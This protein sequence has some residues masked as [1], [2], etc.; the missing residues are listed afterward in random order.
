MS[1]TRKIKKLLSQWEH[2]NVKNEVELVAEDSLM[3]ETTSKKP[4]MEEYLAN[5]YD[6][7]FNVLTGM[8]EYRKKNEGIFCALDERERNTLYME[9]RGDDIKCT[10]SGLLR[11]LHS[12]LIEEFHPFRAYFQMLPAWDGKDRLPDLAKRVSDHPL[13]IKAFHRWMLA[14]AAQW[15]GIGHLHANSV[16]PILISTE[17]GMMKSTFCKSLMPSILEGYYTDK[18]DL[19]A[20]GCLEHKL[21]LMGII[22]LD[23]FDCIPDQ[24]MAQLKN[25]M[26][27]SSVT[28]RQAYKKNF[29]QLPRIASFI[30]TSNRPDLLTDPTGSRRFVCVEVMRK[31]DCSNMEMDHIYAQ[32]KAEL[33]AG[34]RYWFTS[35]EEQEIQEHNASFYQVRP[36]EELIRSRYRAPLSGEQYEMLSLI[37]I[38]DGLRS[39]HSHLLRRCDMKRFGIILQTIG[40]EKVHTRYG[41]RYKVVCVKGEGCER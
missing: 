11:F 4:K 27:M 36:E 10:F 40:M 41:N 1:Q 12:S 24:R 34:E 14:L 35:A 2:E 20:Q 28:I 6:F 39:E 13:W 33:A 26:Q 7:R 30:G 16:A 22:N 19:T 37:E 17:Q 3:P 9:L 38:L 5:R 21:A 8:T 23:E 25:L 15:M 32:L 29:R 31:I 18:A